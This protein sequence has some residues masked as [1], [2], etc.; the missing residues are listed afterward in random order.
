MDYFVSDEQLMAIL[1]ILDPPAENI[2]EIEPR[3]TLSVGISVAGI[4]EDANVRI[5]I[6]NGG[7][8]HRSDVMRADEAA[9]HSY[10]GWNFP[11]RKESGVWH[12]E[13]FINEAPLGVAHE[14]R[15]SR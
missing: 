3:A 6:R 14:V 10:W 12:V 15:V 7:T 9:A 11:V 4:P 5:V 1:E 13:A 2:T 8:V